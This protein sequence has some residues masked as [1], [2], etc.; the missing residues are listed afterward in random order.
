MIKQRIYIFLSVD[1]KD[2]TIY[3]IDSDH[4]LKLAKYENG[5]ISED[6]RISF[7]VNYNGSNIKLSADGKYLYYIKDQSSDDQT[8]TLFYYDIEKDENVRIASDVY[9]EDMYFSQDGKIIYYLKDVITSHKPTNEYYVNDKELGTL[10]QYELGGEPQR[11]SS[12]IIT[13]SLTSGMNNNI[14]N[15][16]SIVWMKYAGELLGI[17]IPSFVILGH[18]L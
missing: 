14:L 15:P 9:T 2:N 3:Y 5:A 18:K 16:K 13:D 11:L 8:G 7:D 6:K 17:K 12:D 4:N 10:Y 1:I